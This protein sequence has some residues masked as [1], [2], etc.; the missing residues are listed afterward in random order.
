MLGAEVAVRALVL[1]LALIQCKDDPNGP[2]GVAPPSADFVLAGGTIAGRGIDDIEIRAGRITAVGGVDP[3]LRRLD[4]T[5][6]WVAPAFI[7][8]HVHGVYRQSGGEQARGG[9]AGAVDWA[10]PLDQVGSPVGPH[11]VWAGPILT[12]PGGYPTQGWGRDGYGLECA[13]VAACADAVDTVRGAGAGVVKVAVG[14]SGP[15]L[16][17]AELAAIVERAHGFDLL[18]GAHAL[19]DAA[20]LRAGRAGADIL[21]HAPTEPLSDETVATWAGRA[22]VPT[23]SAFDGRVAAEQLREAGATVLY[24]TDLG[25]TQTAGISDTELSRMVQSGMDGAAILEAGTVAPARVFGF[26]DLGAVEVGKEASLLVLSL[27]PVVTPTTLASPVAVL[28]R[29]EFLAGALPDQ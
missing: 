5:G 27:N 13:G 14:A 24:G 15:Q 8:A 28:M 26:A 12:A 23:L 6:L 18:V 1:L 11:T 10:A 21:V 16:S 2:P 22:V 4:A 7:D 20:A 3:A 17:D 29:G 9:I 25:N 19:S